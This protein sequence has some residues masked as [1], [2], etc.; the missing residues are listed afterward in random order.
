MRRSIFLIYFF[1][2][3]YS[4]NPVYRAGTLQ[5]QNYI[6]NNEQQRDSSFIVLL[7]PYAD[8]LNKTMNDVLAQVAVRMEKKQP[9][10]TLG[11]FLADAYLIM[12]REK[13]NSKADLALMAP[14]GIRLPSIEAGP[15]KRGTVFEVM[16][17]DN[18]MIL[19]TVKG[20]LLRKYF[21]S[22]AAEG[23]TGIAGFS[24]VV[25]NKKASDIK[26]NGKPFEPSATYIVVNSDYSV[27]NPDAAWLYKDAPRQNTGYLMRDA[28][29]DYARQ[30]KTAGKTIGHNL[31]NRIT[32]AE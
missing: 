24:M 27:N 31:E 8:S 14:G 9:E 11:N 28:I 6:I 5:Y 32:N 23:G 4:C 22:I 16:P 10:S 21:D 1:F 18:L 13:F 17:F 25:R 20:E 3:L 30:L 19:A 26:I 7:Q 12:A 2:L 15:L 29:I